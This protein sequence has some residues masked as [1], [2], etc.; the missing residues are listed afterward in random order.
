MQRLWGGCV[1]QKA[2]RWTCWDIEYELF[3]FESEQ[4]PEFLDLGAESS[5]PLCIAQI[6]AQ[7]Q[8]EWSLPWPISSLEPV[9]NLKGLGDRGWTKL[10]IHQPV[11]DLVWMLQP[12]QI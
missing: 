10:L 7:W 9:L 3:W 11:G 8:E 5:W 4:G 12:T 6:C 2:Q 1:E